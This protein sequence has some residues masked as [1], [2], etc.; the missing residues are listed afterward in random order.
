MSL[1]SISQR[2]KPY[3]DSHNFW[4]SILP[5]SLI[6][7]FVVE[8]IFK[9]IP[10]IP[11][12]NVSPY[13][14]VRERVGSHIAERFAPRFKHMSKTIAKKALAPRKK[15]TAPKTDFEKSLDSRPKLVPLSTTIL[16]TFSNASN[17]A[18]VLL[19][20]IKHAFT[21]TARSILVSH[22]EPICEELAHKHIVVG[23]HTAGAS[24]VDLAT[25][26]IISTLSLP[27]IFN[28]TA[29]ISAWTYLKTKPYMSHLMA[30]NRNWAARNL[31]SIHSI[32]NSF[33]TSTESEDE[34]LKNWI[35]NQLPSVTFKLLCVS[36][37]ITSIFLTYVLWKAYTE[38]E[39]IDQSTVQNLTSDT[40]K[41]SIVTKSKNNDPLSLKSDKD[42]VI[43]LI[44]KAH[45]EPI[46]AKIKEL[47]PT[48]ENT[49]SVNTVNTITKKLI[50][51]V[52][53]YYSDNSIT[54]KPKDGT[55][56]SLTSEQQ[57]DKRLEAIAKKVIA[58]VVDYYWEDL[59][60]I[61]FN[62]LCLRIPLVR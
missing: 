36:A 48:P 43:D 53:D 39:E 33:F 1:F 50:D 4:M 25:K 35:A 11:Y 2:A 56:T 16:E 57:N 40:S 29:K 22:L 14:Y 46:V 55:L 27:W 10:K 7:N 49:E 54:T 20:P 12:I 23:L 34:K 26:Q 38:D 8:K 42:K 61:S 51:K 32:F 47:L 30:D 52:M 13:I 59:T 6:S 19:H 41:E 5:G 3:L 60:E 62:C 17:R 21:K 58:K 45:K 15:K 9:N 37:T 24:T 44:F 31:P 18:N 28:V